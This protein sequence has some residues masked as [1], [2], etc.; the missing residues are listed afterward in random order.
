ML[1]FCC[2]VE[3]EDL[4]RRL[5]CTDPRRRI[6]VPDIISHRWMRMS[7]DDAEFERLMH[8][9]VNPCSEDAGPNDAVLDDMS[10]LGLNKDQVLAVRVCRT[11]TSTLTPIAVSVILD[12]FP[13]KSE[14]LFLFQSKCDWTSSYT[15][16]SHFTFSFGDAFFCKSDFYHIMTVL[17]SVRVRYMQ[18]IKSLNQPKVAQI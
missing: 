9:S 8:S 15:Q 1:L 2:R 5:L 4:I 3:C 17:I 7:G 6:T 13:Y 10:K 11:T 12:L 16:R 18:S 14:Y